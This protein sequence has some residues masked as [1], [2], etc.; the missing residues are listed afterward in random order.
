[1]EKL[2]VNLFHL[3]SER[4]VTREPFEVLADICSCLPVSLYA[5]SVQAQDEIT[6]FRIS[7][8]WRNMQFHVSLIF[9]SRRNVKTQVLRDSVTFPERKLPSHVSALFKL[10]HFRY[11]AFPLCFC[12]RIYSCLLNLPKHKPSRW[13]LEQ[14]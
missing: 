2:D 1:M 5:N 9:T 6:C 12:K 13:F 7:E 4:P 10:A 3:L 14:R 8:T 11:C